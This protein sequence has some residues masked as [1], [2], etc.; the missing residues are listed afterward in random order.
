MLETLTVVVLGLMFICSGLLINAVQL[1]SMVL[2]L[3]ISRNLYRRV[4]CVLSE[5]YWVQLV[6]L[7]DWWG[8]VDTRIYADADTWA[9]MGKEHALLICNHRSDID[10][11]VGWVLAQRTGCLSGT[12]ALMKKSIQY[13]PAIG[14]S[15][16]FSEY[17]FLARDWAKDERTIK[18]AFGRL[19][20]FPVPLWV[21]VFV[22]GTRFTPAKLEAAQKFAA[23]AGLPVPRHTLVPRTKGFVTAVQSMR[24]FVP[25]VYDV[26][27]IV[28]QGAPN[29]TF[30]NLINRKGSIIHVRVKRTPMDE[31]PGDNTGIAAW[32]K[33]RWLEKDSMLAKHIEDGTFGEGLYIPARR[34]AVPLVIT[35]VWAAALALGAA[36]AAVWAVR[37]HAVSLQWTTLAWCLLALVA[38]AAVLHW[39]LS[40]TMSEKST[41]LPPLAKRGQDTPAALHD[42]VGDPLHTE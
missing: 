11:A 10:W 8:G 17:I 33:E 5:V 36:A 4:N 35:C 29:P 37:V 19:H 24:A 14:W 13:L 25:A 30:A 6:W 39:L 34:S 21:A 3:P 27:Q 38:V 9:H 16:W 23:S 15:M 42:G 41:P 32:C 31:L 28:P 40:A 2:L 12:R 22:E 18:D 7:V 1:V 20:G 26:T